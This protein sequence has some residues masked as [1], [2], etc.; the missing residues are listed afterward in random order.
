[1]NINKANV[2]LW[3]GLVSWQSYSCS[4]SQ[5]VTVLAKS[6]LIANLPLELSANKM[7]ANVCF[8]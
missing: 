2:S 6:H 5:S 1:M 3:E 4:Q 8:P 7:D